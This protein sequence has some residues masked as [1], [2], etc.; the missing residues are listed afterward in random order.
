VFPAGIL[1]PPFFHRDFPRVMNYGA[2][3]MGMGHELTHGFDDQGRKFDAHGRL[4]EWWDPAVASRFEERARCVADLFDSYEVEPGLH[5]NGKQT[6]GE[7]IADLGGLK[8]AYRAYKAWEG[9]QAKP[10]ASPVPGLDN[11]QLFFVAF[12]QPWCELITPEYARLL[13]QADDHAADRYRV[14]AAV[15]QFPDFARVF[16][17]TAGAPM[18]PE[19]RCQVW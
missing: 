8:E 13:A 15:S 4:R 9:A 1:Q 6:L 19:K 3:G 5:L 14:L 12:A 18:N 2:I 11:D 17:C 16:A 10:P 7:D